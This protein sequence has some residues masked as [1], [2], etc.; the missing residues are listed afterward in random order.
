VRVAL[1]ATSRRIVRQL[2]TE[3]LILALAGGIAGLVIGELALKPLVAFAGIQDLAGGA[4]GINARILAFTLAASCA[5]GVIFG[6]VPAASAARPDLS[7]R[8]KEGARGSTSGSHRRTQALLLVSE[9]ALTVLLLVCAGLLL[10]SFVKAMDADPGFRA[11]NVMVFNLTV[12]NSRAPENADKVRLGQIIMERLGRI[13]GVSDVGMGSSVPMNGGNG[14]GDLVSREDRPETRNDFQAGFDS[15]AG[16]YFKALRVPL[17]SGRFLTRQDDSGTAPKVMLVNDALAKMLFG[18]ENPL[19]RQLHFKDDAWEIVG[20]VGS[21]RRYALD[22]GATPQV[23]FPQT[24]FPWRMCVLVRTRAP[25]PTLAN[26]VRLALRDIDPDLPVAD[27]RMLKESIASTLQVRRI[28]LVL[29]SIFAVTALVLACIGIYGVISYSVAQRT[30][31]VGIRMALGAD[32]GRVV[33]L[34]LRQGFNLVLVGLG[35]GIAASLGA[36]LLIANQ[37]Y[38]VSKTDPVVMAAVI[39]ILCAVALLASWLPARRAAK[40]N[41]S[42][43]LRSE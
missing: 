31:E 43:A 14:L 7:N 38:D 19:G 34:V 21:V 39:L 5:T 10:R 35:I 3:S 15:V 26:E 17:L 24:Y 30:R 41:P 40:V 18:K 1:G 23:Y 4:I 33:A 25:A 16:D 2:L 8:L 12:P 28:V 27:L 37:L 42:V 13:P 11:D 6:L 36:G 9:T 29:L 32:S 22:Y 20:V